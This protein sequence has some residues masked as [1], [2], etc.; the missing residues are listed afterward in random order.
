MQKDAHFY[1]TYVIARMIGIERRDARTI[2]W[3]DQYTDDMTQDDISAYGI[4]TQCDLLENWKDR[5]IQYTV[6]VPFHF[7]PG[8]DA[9]R[10]WVT[11]PNCRLSQKLIAPAVW[12]KD[13][14]RMGIAL[15]ALQDTFS[16][17]G[18]SGWD[19]KAN[20]CYP[21]YYLQSALPNVGHTEMQTMPDII[22]AVWTDPRNNE[23]IVNADRAALAAEATFNA[24]GNYFYESTHCLAQISWDDIRDK[25]CGTFTMGYDERKA[26]LKKLISTSIQYSK[27]RP[28]QL[29]LH[30]GRKPFIRA[31]R[32]Q[33]AMVMD[34]C[35][36][37]S[38]E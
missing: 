19:E 6:L 36:N 23:Y 22:H 8:D 33:L 32:E 7:L 26:A 2:A 35:V 1:M 3:A 37:L 16:H 38:V 15:H 20:S 28:V 30:E 31:A 21:W 4:Q 17:Q 25:I 24:L 13:P 34:H 5:E 18:F 29:A 14:Y 10:P 11:T 9:D 12:N 27:G